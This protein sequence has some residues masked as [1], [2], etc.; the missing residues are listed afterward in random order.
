[1]WGMWS[2]A[3]DVVI[4]DDKWITSEEEELADLFFLLSPGVQFSQE[5]LDKSERGIP[6]N[7]VLG[8]GAYQ[9][10]HECSNDIWYVL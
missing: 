8:G 7:T 6:G 10:F 3:T 4:D 2:I 5:S 9:Q 1:M